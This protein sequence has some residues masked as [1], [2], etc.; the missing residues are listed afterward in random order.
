MK[1]IF[2]FLAVASTALF[3]SCGSDDSS[4]TPPIGSDDDGGI[5]VPTSIEVAADATSK[6]VGGTFTFTVTN[7]LGVNVTASS[8]FTVNDVAI[9]G[10][11]FTPENAG[12]YTVVATNGELVSEAITITAT[13]QV[14]VVAD[15]SFIYNGQNYETPLTYF[16]YRGIFETEAGSGEYVIFWDFNPFKEVQNGDQYFYPNDVYITLVYSITPTGTNPDTGAP[17]FTLQYPVAGSYS[18]S[19]T[20]LPAIVDAFVV[21]GD[22]ELDTDLIESVDLNISEVTF[23][24]SSNLNATYTITLTDGQVIEG[25]SSG[26]TGAYD[27]TN[28]GRPGNN[29][30]VRSN[31]NIRLNTTNLM[32]SVR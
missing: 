4:S 28:G 3:T 24:E 23:G 21:Y 19:A 30:V 9:T 15:N 27:A 26:P 31:K 22:N 32:L 12:T 10:P 29:A 2:C 8:T 7:N 5:V 13:T 16:G 6:E 11:T 14:P 1:K 20:S 17:T 18:T 25:A